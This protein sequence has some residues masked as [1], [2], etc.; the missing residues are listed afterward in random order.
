MQLGSVISIAG[1]A[2]MKFVVAD[3][4]EGGMGIVFGL[5]PVDLQRRDFAL[6]ALSSRGNWE[7]AEREARMWISLGS[8]DGLAHAVWAGLWQE[9]P[10]ILAH[11][12]PRTVGSVDPCT[13]NGESFVRFIAK[14]LAALNY[15]H[16]RCGLIHRDIKPSNIL[17][18]EEGGPRLADFGVAWLAP[19]S[20][21]S[22]NS[23]DAIT[24]SLM[25]CVTTESFQGTPFYMAPEL[26][27]KVPPSVKTDLFSLA[28]TLYQLRSS[29]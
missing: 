23:S 28:V 29:S 22:L 24:K 6:K 4:R 16:E 25:T 3:R 8:H 13:W 18:D 15:A 9:R 14:V 7:M 20:P 26:F 17:L 2:P 1:F 10:A 27:L 5:T 12:Y 21:V 11:W 19:Q